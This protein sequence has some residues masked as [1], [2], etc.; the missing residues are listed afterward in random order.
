MNKKHIKALHNI[1]LKH[2]EITSKVTEI[3][4]DTNPTITCIVETHMLK[5][6]KD[7]NP[8]IRKTF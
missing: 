5:Y 4:D 2:R 1:L 7:K 3:V 8:R 6:E